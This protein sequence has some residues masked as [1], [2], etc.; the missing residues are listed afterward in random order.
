MIIRDFKPADINDII[1]IEYE[2]FRHPYPIDIILQ[3]YEAGAGFLVAE[4]SSNILGYIIF[5]LKDNIGHIIV[6]AVDS[7]Y[8]GMSIGSLLLQNALQIFKL[9]GI[10][11][12]KLEVKKT[13]IGAIHFYQENNFKHIG[14]EENYY[15]DGETAVIMLYTHEDL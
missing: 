7:R 14:E 6:I 11:D 2:S 9:N 12:I 3:L 15:E 8:R 4:D 1:R 10:K 13:N 5:W